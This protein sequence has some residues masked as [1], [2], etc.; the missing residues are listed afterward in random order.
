[1]KDV[2]FSR[3]AECQKSGGAGGTASCRG[4]RG[5]AP[6]PCAAALSPQTSVALFAGNGGQLGV[7]RQAG[8]LSKAG[9]NHYSLRRTV[10]SGVG[11][12][13]RKQSALAPA[14]S[15][16]S[17]QVMK[18]C[19]GAALLNRALRRLASSSLNTSSRQQRGRFAH[20]FFDQADFA[21]LHAQNGG[22]QLTLTAHGPQIFA[23][24][25]AGSHRPGA[26]RRW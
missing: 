3:S 19:S 4:Y 26:G 15:C 1:M 18:V 10:P 17:V 11:V 13:R 9:G 7:F 5:S 8:G 16:R 20:F 25:R 14:A 22:A 2:A 12:T 21:Q 24:Q 6:N 23:E